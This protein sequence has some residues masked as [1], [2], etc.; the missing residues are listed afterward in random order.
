MLLLPLLLSHSQT[1]PSAFATVSFP[2]LLLCPILFACHIPR[3]TS[4][5]FYYLSSQTWLL[6]WTTELP[7]NSN[8]STR[9]Y[10]LAWHSGY[11]ANSWMGPPMCVCLLAT[12]VTQ[13]TVE[14]DHPCVFACL[15]QW[16]HSWVCSPTNNNNLRQC[17]PVNETLSL[18]K[19]GTYSL[20]YSTLR[21][22]DSLKSLLPWDV[23]IHL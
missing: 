16:L 12:V 14:W 6:T 15:P 20:N 18:R 9:V 3:P 8:E 5:S 1:S 19:A 21:F 17:H 10:L 11:T 2:D 4:A 23:S 7:D 13:L 22:V